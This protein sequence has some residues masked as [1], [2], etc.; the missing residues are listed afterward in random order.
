MIINKIKYNI[1]E[2]DFSR[3]FKENFDVLLL[4]SYIQSQQINANP[5][6]DGMEIEGDP[7]SEEEE[8]EAEPAVWSLRK[9]FSVGLFAL[10]V[11][12]AEKLFEAVYRQKSIWGKISL[13][14]G[15]YIG[16]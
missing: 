7:V 5:S 16:G 10:Y 9:E 4:L 3:F 13:R 14:Y 15:R 6:E 12:F 2:G 1:K 8:E 11:C